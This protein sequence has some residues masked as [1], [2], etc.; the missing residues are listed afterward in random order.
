MKIKIR[1]SVYGINAQPIKELNSQMDLKIRVTL[2]AL[3]IAPVHCA[4]NDIFI[5]TKSQMEK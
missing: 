2:S 3:L 1:D 5:I 4:A